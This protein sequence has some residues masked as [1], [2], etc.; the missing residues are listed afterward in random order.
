M[1]LTGQLDLNAL[2]VFDAVVEAGS[3]TA[4]ADRL[5]IAKA[6]VSIQVARLETLLGAALFARTTR[7]VTLTDAG[8]ALH[9]ECHP[10]LHGIT[11]A[12][13]R[14]GARTTELSGTLRLST[15]VDHAVQSLA[16]AVASFAEEHPRLQIDLR[17]SDRV[18]DLVSEGIDLSIRLGWLR[19]SSLRAV[20]LGEFS[21]YLVASPAYVQ[22]AGL[23]THPQELGG[24]AWVALTLLPTPLT[25]HFTAR[26]GKVHTAHVKTRLRV[27]SPGA[28]AAMLRQGAG[29]SVLDQ[30]TAQENIASG[31]LVRLLPE[32]QLPSGGIYAVYPPGRHV[33]ARVRT[34]IDFY[35]ELLRTP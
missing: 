19:D 15:S 24:Y 26:E 21:Q 22:R 29:I 31:K 3:F 12:V 1:S 17:T 18:V 28:L 4:A 33:S 7:R 14:V 10:L 23:P 34:F 11:E 13:D 20:K 2:L 32:W 30:Y 8:R 6:K 25:W 35:R 16:A 27:D 5:G 9:A